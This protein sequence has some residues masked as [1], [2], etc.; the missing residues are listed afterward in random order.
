MLFQEELVRGEFNGSLF[1]TSADRSMFRVLLK[2]MKPFLPDSTPTAAKYIPLPFSKIEVVYVDES[3]VPGYG[4]SLLASSLCAAVLTDL[5][6]S[7]EL[8]EQQKSKKSSNQL[9]SNS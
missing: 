7:R 3:G 4:V 5:Y 1:R 9:D 8:I 6:F 2:L